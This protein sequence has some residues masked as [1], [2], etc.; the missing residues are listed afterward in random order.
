MLVGAG[1]GRRRRRIADDAAERAELARL[2]REGR[3]MKL[4]RVRVSCLRELGAWER[5][6]DGLERETLVFRERKC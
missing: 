2:E 3:G 4:L 5:L 6:G 1:T